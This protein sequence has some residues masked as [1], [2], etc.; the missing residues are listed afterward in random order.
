MFDPNCPNGL[1]YAPGSP[2]KDAGN[3]YIYIKNSPQA[4][5]VSFPT[6]PDLADFLG[7]TIF[8][9]TEFLF[10]AFLGIPYF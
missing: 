8:L 10:L 3:I 6:H 2:W 4:Q 9:F 1:W 7:Q 5:N